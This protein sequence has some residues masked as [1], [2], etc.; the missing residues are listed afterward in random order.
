[1]YKVVDKRYQEIVDGEIAGVINAPGQ[2][3]YINLKDLRYDNV[4]DLTTGVTG[5][6]LCYELSTPTTISTSAEDITLL[7]GN[8]VLSTNADDMELKYSVSLDS[9]LPTTTRT[10]AKSPIVEEPKEET[11]ET[12]EQ[13]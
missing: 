8:N 10:L 4:S 3:D 1:M 2:N 5:S 11:D 6:K 12:E 13:R 9:L 7:K